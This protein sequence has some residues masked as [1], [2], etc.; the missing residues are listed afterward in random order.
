MTHKIITVRHRGK[1][2][3]FNRS[4]RVFHTRQMAVYDGNARAPSDPNRTLRA[5]HLAKKRRQEERRSEHDDFVRTGGKMGRRHPHLK[6]RL[7][8]RYPS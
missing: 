7:D 8:R 6:K 2:T 3:W 4:P 5:L 1:P